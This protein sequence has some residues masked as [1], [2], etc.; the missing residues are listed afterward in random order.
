MID[1]FHQRRT[2]KL[3]VIASLV[4]MPL[5]ATTH[6]K[7]LVKH[8]NSTEN[9]GK[10]Y[11]APQYNLLVGARVAA[12][13]LHHW[14]SPILGGGQHLLRAGTPIQ[15]PLNIAK[16]GG[17]SAR[18]LNVERRGLP[19]IFD[20]HPNN[21]LALL[22]VARKFYGL[23]PEI[24]PQLSPL[25]GAGM[26]VLS[27]RISPCLAS[28]LLGNFVGLASGGGVLARNIESIGSF[29]GVFLGKSQSP[30]V[31]PQGHPQA[32]DPKRAQNKLPPSPLSGLRSGIRSLPLGAKIVVA[33]IPMWPAWLFLFRGLDS[34]GGFGGR[35]RSVW[36][37]FASFGWALSFLGASGLFWWLCGPY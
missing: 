35:R 23:Y 15:R 25:A 11:V 9:V 21:R 17:N 31:E 2:K 33:A 1:S 4:A 27:L 13:T 24:G 12:K 30:K 8:P 37:A 26:F 29:S 6:E 34:L 10:F 5:L 14:Q 20:R 22:S 32:H 7:S 28:G 3:L 36:H 16:I 19:V 18:I